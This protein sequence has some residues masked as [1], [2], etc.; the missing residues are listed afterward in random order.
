M[1]LPLPVPV[2]SADA[3]EVSR[4]PA[5]LALDLRRT[6]RGTRLMQRRHQGPLYVQRP[7]YPEGPELAHIYLLHP[8]GGLVSGD[9]L[10]FDITLGPEAATLLTTPGAA[11]IY[12]AREAITE[13]RQQVHLNLA[14]GCSAEWLPMETIVFPGARARL[15]TRVDLAADSHFI[16]WEISCT[17]LPASGEDFARGKLRQTFQ[18]YR[19]G[20]ALL[21]ET[22]NLDMEDERLYRHRAGLGGN[23][24][25]GLMVATLPGE[26]DEELVALLRE[27]DDRKPPV[28]AVTAIASLVLLRYLGPCT[29]QARRLFECAWHTLR[30]QVLGRPACEPRIWRT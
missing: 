12:R 13:Q 5:T 29:Q 17:G 11:R 27:L 26:P 21:V 15:D 20:K 30:P 28:L 7:F 3:R 6:P 16:G 10:G 24:V 2:A 9:D 25:S 23:N 18:L 19:E 4:W 1:N 14:T 22:L 8:P